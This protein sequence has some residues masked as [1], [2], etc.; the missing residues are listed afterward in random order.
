MNEYIQECDFTKPFAVKLGDEP[1]QIDLFNAIT[2]L[3]YQE[4]EENSIPYQF[5]EKLSA[6]FINLNDLITNKMLT[7][8][9]KDKADVEQLQKI[10]KYQ[11]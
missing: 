6:R 5:S 3:N 2:G 7:G 10:R 9:L 11:D 8:R 1:I 4:A